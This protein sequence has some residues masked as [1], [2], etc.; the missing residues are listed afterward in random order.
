VPKVVPTYAEDAKKRILRAASEE[1]R[2]KGYFQ[3]TMDGIA[4]RLGISKGAIYRYFESKEKILSALY[5]TAPDN[6]RSLFLGA[7]KDPVLA[8]REVFDKMAT[9]SNANLF[10]DFLAE[11]SVNADLQRI[12]QENIERFSAALEDVIS[13][14]N[15]MK[16]KTSSKS[17]ETMHDSIV[18]LGLVFNGLLCWLAIGVS[19]VEVRETWAKAVDILLG[20]ALNT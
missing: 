10:V 18:T 8:S 2:E 13:Q 7:S 12:M 3:S 5:A 14:K 1:F 9:K 15:S 11:A 4:N 20:A 16:R 19:E 6:L 17:S